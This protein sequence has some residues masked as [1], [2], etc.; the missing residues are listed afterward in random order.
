MKEDN[1]WK[2]RCQ[3]QRRRESPL[4]IEGA[5]KW[6]YWDDLYGIGYPAL[7]LGSLYG[8]NFDMKIRQ[9]RITKRALLLALLTG[10]CFTAG[11]CLD[12]G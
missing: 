4:L 8:G 1:G 7:D 2:G 5:V 12:G 3:R 9:K 6:Y 10:L 11:G